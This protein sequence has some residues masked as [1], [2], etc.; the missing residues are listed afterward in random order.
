MPHY[1]L[2]CHS[3]HS[4]GLLTPSAVVARAAARD[5]DVLA[6]T[7]H[8]ELSGLAE[9]R[10][11]AADAGI[12]LVC[13]SEL[14]VSW[15]DHTLH[16]VALGIDPGNAALAAGLDAIRVGR[17]ARARRIGDALAAAGIE[18]AFEGAMRYVTSERLVSRT[19]F[20]RF[21]VEAGYARETK[22]VFQRYLTRGNPG[23][24][25]HPWATLSEAVGWIH[26]AGG[27]AVIAHPGRYKINRS[28]MRRL[29][30]EFHDLGGDA[31]EVL[32]PSHTPAQYVEFATY[33][34]TFELRASCG[35]DW[36]GPGESWMDFGELPELPPGTVPVWK[37]W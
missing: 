8:D 20:A 34:R 33:S 17:A 5:V 7:D 15:D 2:H 11:A 21:L 25:P 29:L 18:G 16:I 6:L 37:S 14:S 13:G 24:V 31:I 35:S 36:H 22:D 26:A 28:D 23:Y 1:D 27:Q 12:E 10:A 19:H 30:A 9:A 4:D 32:S 3:T